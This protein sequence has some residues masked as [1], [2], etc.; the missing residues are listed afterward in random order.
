M[1]RSF[2]IEAPKD[3][4][5]YYII[6]DDV[7][8]RDEV[9]NNLKYHQNKMKSVQNLMFAMIYIIN[10]DKKRDTEVN[11][12]HW[13]YVRINGVKLFYENYFLDEKENIIYEMD[14]KDEITIL[15]RQLKLKKII[16]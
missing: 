12:W 13:N 14:N 11:G 7:L 16:K 9:L 6:P 1:I 4:N 8:Y 15:Q 2:K 10:K 5:G 3:E